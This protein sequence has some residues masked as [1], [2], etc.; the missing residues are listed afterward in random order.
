M[1]N[2]TKLA[3]VTAVLGLAIGGWAIAQA[4]QS[5]ALTHMAQ[6]HGDADSMVKHLT[7]AFPKVAAFDANKDGKLDET[8]KAALAKAIADG[9]LQLP[10][11]AMAD[12]AGPSPEMMADHIAEMFAR[13]VAYDA[14]HD[15][16]LDA[17]EQ[18]A[19]KS[20]IEKG[21]FTPHDPRPHVGESQR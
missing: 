16:R 1:K 10:G 2:I 6:Y 12:G 3:M 5:G 7:E 18:A 20:A 14:N 15:G 13:I 19:L 21:E 9:T 8:E 4:H 11:H 17:N